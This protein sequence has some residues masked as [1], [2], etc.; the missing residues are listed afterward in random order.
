MSNILIIDDD[1]MMCATLQALVE[2]QGHQTSSAT[3]LRDGFA[4]VAQQQIDLVFLDVHLPDGSGLD[5]LARIEASPCSPEVIIV[6]GYGDPNGAELA[7][8]SGAWDYIEK[9]FSI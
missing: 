8:N 2:R 5:A 4:C 7:I 9:G 3:T 6:T 1:E